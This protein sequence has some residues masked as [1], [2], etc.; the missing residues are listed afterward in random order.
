MTNPK[1]IRA[2]IN[3][4]YPAI[5][6]TIHPIIETGISRQAKQHPRHPKQNTTYKKNIHKHS[7]QDRGGG[8]TA[9]EN[10]NI[11]NAGMLIDKQ[12]IGADIANNPSTKQSANPTIPMPPS[13]ARAPHGRNGKAIAP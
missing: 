11:K 5:I 4:I 7:R 6:A 8:K 3:R 9:I 2:N 10:K 13:I 1:I 12:T